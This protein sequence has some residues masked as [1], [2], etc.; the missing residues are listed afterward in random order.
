M[1][2]RRWSSILTNTHFISVDNAIKLCEM[3]SDFLVEQ[4]GNYQ[5]LQGYTQDNILTCIAARQFIIKIREGKIKYF[6]CWFRMT[7]KEAQEMANYRVRPLNITT[8]PV[9]Y[10]AEFA[11]TEGNKGLYE[12]IN[13]LRVMNPDAEYVFWHRPTKE[14]KVYYFKVRGN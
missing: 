8:G 9:V 5:Q 11:N 2:W 12:C 10:V 14:D 13:K 1:S 6:M 7:E 4:G 3:I